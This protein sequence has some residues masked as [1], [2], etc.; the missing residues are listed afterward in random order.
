MGDPAP[1]PLPPPY[2]SP[3][4]R[5]RALRESGRV[6]RWAGKDGSG[7]VCPRY[8]AGEDGQRPIKSESLGNLDHQNI[9]IS[10]RLTATL[11]RGSDQEEAER[12]ARKGAEKEESGAGSNHGTR[13]GGNA[14][15]H[16][17]HH[18][19]TIDGAFQTE[20][21]RVP[22]GSLGLLM[23]SPLGGG[24]QG[25]IAERLAQ[26]KPAGG[27]SGDPRSQRIAIL[28]SDTAMEEDGN[29]DDGTEE[30]E[31]GFRRGTESRIGGIVDMQD[32]VYLEFDEEEEIKQEPTEPT[33]WK[34]LARY[35]ANFKP[36]T[37]AMF[38]RFTNEVW[39][40]RSGIRYSEKGKNYYMITLF[41]KGDYDYV[42]RGGPWIFNQNALLVK[43]LDESAQPSESVLNSVP[44]WVQIYDMPWDKQDNVWGRRYGNG[45]GEAIEVD[46]LANE[47]EKKEFF[48]MGH[49]KDE[50][51]KR[52]LGVPSLDYDAHELRCSPYKKFEH[53]TFF[54]PPAG[55]ALARRG[56][57][58]VSFGSAESHKRFRHRESRVPWEPRWD[59]VT[60]EH[61]NARYVSSENEMPPLEDDP[62]QMQQGVGPVQEKEAGD[63]RGAKPGLMEVESSLVDKVDALR[64]GPSTDKEQGRDA[65]QPI[66]QFPEEEG[67]NPSA[68]YTSDV[69][70]TMTPDMLAQMQNFQARQ[71][72]SSSHNSW[73]HGPRQ[74]DMI[75]AL[76]GLS[77]LQV[78]FGSVNDISMVPADTVLGKRQAV[79]QE[80]Q[81]GR[82]ELSLG[83][84][85]GGKQQGITPKKGKTQ[86]ADTEKRQ[87]EVVYRRNKKST[88]TGH[89]PTGN[90][91]RPNVWSRQEQ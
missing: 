34:L 63:M 76:Q 16:P 61:A 42:M 8:G 56:L 13:D 43:D 81:G 75:P 31:T 44:V 72:A 28:G 7:G 20:R 69:H 26:P 3:A 23:A 62:V 82:L 36:N 80:V 87:V 65:S 89:K 19:G 48:F 78:S 41:S 18:E 51:E 5:R 85:Y 1:P 14:V 70:I 27:A 71:E 37:K 58:F 40:L 54:S 22:P 86:D 90:L 25:S 49:K 84:D 11:A 64:M 60:P 91:T 53:R 55:H 17:G 35:M 50:C 9:E 59:S 29:W 30:E 46:V 79:E 12:M 66:I 6:T 83:L 68:T 67:Q 4:E 2:E 57:S 39:H 21:T 73:R 33:T 88:A 10:N 38:D 47:Q 45:L 52:R 15:L 24:E 74:S 77:S 32:D